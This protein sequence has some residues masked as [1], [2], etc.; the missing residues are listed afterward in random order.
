MGL[1][2][3]FLQ[4]TYDNVSG[5]SGLLPLQA[6]LTSLVGSTEDD[7]VLLHVFSRYFPQELF[8]DLLPPH[9]QFSQAL[10]AAL[11]KLLKKV[12]VG[13]LKACYKILKSC[14]AYRERGEGKGG[15]W[16]LCLLH[17]LLV[18]L[19]ICASLLFVSGAF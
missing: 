11:K 9:T 19:F 10:M 15:W 6:V 1:L 12:V 4:A 16:T 17:P 13:F 8:Q 7:N 5:C 14:S 2:R 3:G 18:S